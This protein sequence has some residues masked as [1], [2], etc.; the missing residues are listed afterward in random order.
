M[1]KYIDMIENE[2][3]RIE[4]EFKQFYIFLLKSKENK[5]IASEFKNDINHNNKIYSSILEQRINKVNELYE[6][7]KGGIEE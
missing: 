7:L 1:K 5:K 4:E 6:V 3:K 2:Q